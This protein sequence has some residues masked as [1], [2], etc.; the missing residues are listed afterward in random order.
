MGVLLL[1]FVLLGTFAII[2]AETHA[3][4]NNYVYESW[5][6]KSLPP[7][8]LTQQIHHHSSAHNKHRRS[9]QA[10]ELAPLYPGY[11]THFVYIYV[12]TPPQRQTVIVDTGSHLTAFPCTGCTQCGTHTDSYFN[13]KNSSSAEVLKCL[14]N[15]PCLVSQSYTEG[16]SW[17]GYKMKDKVFVSDSQVVLLPGAEKLA[18]TF[19]FACQTA[20][21]G[22]FRTQ[23]ADGIM[24]LSMS[25]DTLPQVLFQQKL[26]ASPLFAL[27]FRVGGG[28]LSL[29]GVD[30]RLHAGSGS[31][32]SNKRLG[33]AKL[34]P[35]RGS[36]GGAG[37]LFGVLLREIKVVNAKGESGS[38]PAASASAPAAGTASANGGNGLLAIVDSG[39]TDTYLPASMH[40][41]FA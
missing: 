21:T 28:I 38:V 19:P 26:I 41:P 35:Q 25:E 40:A 13:P 23:L 5:M 31:G 9:L 8:Q 14:N 34:H 3:A 39:T 7:P 29:G 15:Q 33:F 20:E 11:G 10:A 32:N 2:N 1:F 27:C 4:G 17:H 16:S 18:A 37:T 24:G 12:G 6:D 30:Q 22:L 36:L